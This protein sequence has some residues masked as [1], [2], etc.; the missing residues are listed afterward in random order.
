MEGIYNAGFENISIL[1]IAKKIAAYM[2]AEIIISES[3]D[4]RSYRLCS[5]KL[6][7]A[8]FKQSHNVD[9]AIKELAGEFRAGNLNNEDNWYNI[10]TMNKLKLK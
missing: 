3:N 9:D 4:P 8:G 5:N 10:R 2:S 7:A 1:E 6:L